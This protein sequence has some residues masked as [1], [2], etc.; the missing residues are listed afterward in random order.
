MGKVIDLTGQVFGRLT[1]ISRVE[2]SLRGEAR[3]L[4]ECA[5]GNQSTVTTSSLRSRNTKSCGCL[6]SESRIATNTTHGM[7][8]TKEYHA[9]ENIKKRVF[10]PSHPGYAVYS[11][12][13]M[14]PILAESFEAFYQEIGPCP[15]S[16]DGIRYSVDRIDNTKGYVPGNIRWAT[17]AQQVRNQGMKSTNTSGVTGVSVR[18]GRPGDFHAVASWNDLNG[19]HHSKNFSFKKYGEEEAFRLACEYRAKMIEELNKQGAGYTVSH[20][21]SD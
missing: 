3:W 5:C 11:K 20:G 15:T 17:A 6:K 13:G 10:N 18:E 2:S 16:S 14:D 4:C 1:V 12:L 21:K 7:S 8:H 9:W 19:K